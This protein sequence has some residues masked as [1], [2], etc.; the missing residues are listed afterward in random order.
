MIC[1]SRVLS[2]CASGP[3][4]AGRQMRITLK[5]LEYFVA[6][7][8]MGSIKLAAIRINI[9]QPSISSAISHLEREFG[10]QLFVRHHAQGLALTSAGKTMLREAK[11]MLRQAQG[12]YTMA[13]ELNNEIRGRLSVGCMVTLAPMIAPQLAHAFS[14]RHPGVDLNMVDGGHQDLM[15]QLRQVEIDVAICYDLQIPADIQFEPLASLR[16]YV[17]VSRSHRFARQPC[18]DMSELAA[19]PMVILD[20]PQSREYF[21]S[22]FE[23]K[24]LEPTIVARAANQE[25]VR[26]MVANNYGFTIANVR[27]R[28]PAAL[29]GRKLVPVKLA[30]DHKPMR[31]GI[32]TL[33]QERKPM[34]LTVFEEHCRHLIT[35]ASIPG[36][37]GGEQDGT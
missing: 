2:G 19:E 11:L 26:T 1:F 34:I 35:D 10:V 21:I 18:V 8:D 24:G 16:P 14:E 17:L 33:A 27:P 5:Q 7:G 15:N 36:M 32:S 37:T 13:G 3:V 6:A 28:N 20:L 31:I 22:L 9:S 23:S 29:D 12:L 4:T 30:G 25:V